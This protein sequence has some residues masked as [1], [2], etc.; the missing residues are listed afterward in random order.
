M[1]FQLELLAERAFCVVM[2]VPGRRVRPGADQLLK[3][4][5][6]FPKPAWLNVCVQVISQ[7]LEAGAGCIRVRQWC[8]GGETEAH[9]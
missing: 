9:K 8:F 6:D 1:D 7:V 5:F 3:S 4:D 2:Y